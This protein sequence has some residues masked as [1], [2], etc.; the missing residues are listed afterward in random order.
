M[1]RDKKVGRTDAISGK[2]YDAEAG[3]KKKR[4]R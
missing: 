1:A 2:D 3:R 4:Y